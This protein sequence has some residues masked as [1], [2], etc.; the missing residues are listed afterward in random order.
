[1][2]TKKQSA[3]ES[4]INI[5]VGYCV[6]IVS[7]Y[8]I[9]PFFNIVVSHTEHLVIGAWFTV[10]SFI[11]SYLLRR[12]F[13]YRHTNMKPRVVHSKKERYDVYIGRPSKWGNPFIVGTH[14][15]RDQCI[16]LYKEYIHKPEQHQ[17]LLDARSELVGK[18][19]GCF[20]A[21]KACHGDVLLEIANVKEEE[22]PGTTGA[23]Q[24]NQRGCCG[25]G[26]CIPSDKGVGC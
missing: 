16:K 12:Y 9:F 3:W 22:N 13:N 21:P 5:F 18:T 1:M 14:G 4:F 23:V 19:L 2:Q 15:P 10:I 20:C 8:L 24:T 17:L 7:Q 11:R 26:S 25:E 6:A